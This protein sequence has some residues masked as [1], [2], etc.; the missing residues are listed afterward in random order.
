MI[1]MM[2]QTFAIFCVLSVVC[3]Y[4]LAFGP[5]RDG[6]IGGLDLIGLSGV[7]A[8]PHSDYAPTVP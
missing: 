2:L 8:M 1:G 5:D 4:S 7:G 3:N 6:V